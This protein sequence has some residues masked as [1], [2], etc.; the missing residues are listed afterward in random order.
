MTLER[1]YIGGP[2]LLVALSG[3]DRRQPLGPSLEAASYGVGS[4]VTAPSNTNA[5]PVSRSRIDVSWQDNSTNETGFEVH[6]STSG[7]TG[8]FTLRASI[9]AGVTSYSDVGLT[10]STQYCYK[11]RAVRITGGK[12]TYS[13]FSAAACATTLPPPPPA[14]PLGTDAKPASST[15]VDVTWIDNST[16]EDGFRLERS[17]DAGSTWTSAGTVGPNLTS[18]QEGGRSS[19]QPVC[20]RITA[21]N[22][23][24]D[25]PPSNTDC[26]TPPAAPSGLTATAVVDQPAID[27]T[28]TDKSAVEDGYEVLRDD[29]DHGLR[30]VAELPANSTSYRDAGVGSNT[31]YS[32]HV[33]AKKDGGFSDLSD[34]ASAQCVAA[35]CPARCNGNFDCG[36]GD[37]CVA[38]V[39]VPH[40]NDGVLD[41][42]ESDVDCGGDACVARCLA[43]RTCNVNGDCASG[44]CYYGICQP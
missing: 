27:L 36:L 11:M 19:E 25:S 15:I 1:F 22:G 39:C 8:T 14:A 16:N 37:I 38:Y 6:R 21:F 9:G 32:Y 2:L 28:W 3:C 30:T 34:A 24:G 5:T 43:G 31:T 13:D 41:G 44:I 42:D 29:M 33:R 40:C 26:T 20:Y 35:T 12:T 17:L 23:G 10:A 7:P 4:S 18:F